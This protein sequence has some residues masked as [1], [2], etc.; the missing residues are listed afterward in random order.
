MSCCS[1]PPATRS[2]KRKGSSNPN[3][4]SKK[5]DK[6]QPALESESTVDKSKLADVAAKQFTLAATE[7][8]RLLANQ[9]KAN[10]ENYGTILDD[11]Q[12]KL[13]LEI[14]PAAADKTTSLTI[15]TQAGAQLGLPEQDSPATSTSFEPQ[16]AANLGDIP[17][18]DALNP[19]DNEVLGGRLNTSLFDR[20]RR[21]SDDIGP[22]TESRTA[23]QVDGQPVTQEKASIS[24]VGGADAELL[25]QSGAIQ[26][27]AGGD[28]RQFYESVLTTSTQNEPSTTKLGDYARIEYSPVEDLDSV[29]T[30]SYSRF[31]SERGAGSRSQG[32]S[33]L[34]RQNSI[35]RAA[36]AAEEGLSR[37]SSIGGVEST[38]LS[39]ASQL[40]NEQFQQN[41]TNML[42]SVNTNYQQTFGTI[43]LPLGPPIDAA[44]V[45]E[46]TKTSPETPGAAL[47][48]ASQDSL[49]DTSFNGDKTSPKPSGPLT[50]R[51]NQSSTGGGALVSD[52]FQQERFILDEMAELA[53]P[54]PLATSEDDRVDGT[55]STSAVASRGPEPPDGGK[56]DSGR[57]GSPQ[58]I[59]T[60][61]SGGLTNPTPTPS[62]M[63]TGSGK[64]KKRLKAKTLFKK[65]KPG[66][67]KKNKD[68]LVESE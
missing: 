24:I 46:T 7:G 49:S 23:R 36:G 62:E 32:G 60:N 35:G 13:I 14:D 54:A 11:A 47:T 2:G 1:A 41:L 3:L 48:S 65:F 15:V 30:M 5:A 28:Q 61:T 20:D 63:S 50:D 17:D 34:S 55:P 58:S 26:Q 27:V 45:T 37:R 10:D 9:V 4:Q 25:D 42:E 43:G 39:I 16:Q 51:S 6:T 22:R 29:T 33:T 38:S 19:A 64:K 59:A 21:A 66:G 67:K 18:R 53:K 8:D 56:T 52:S 31:G 68:E 44:F 57:V 12:G 40:S